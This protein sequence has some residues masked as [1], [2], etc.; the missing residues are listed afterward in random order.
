MSVERGGVILLKTGTV[1]DGKYK[2]LRQIGRGGMSVVYLAVNEKANK[3]W[4]VK[5]VY[6]ETGLGTELVRGRL[7]AETE[8]LK[9][10]HHPGL[11]AVA[12][13]IDEGES[14][15]IVMDYI[16]GRSLKEVLVREG[17][18]CREQA[19]LWGK[20]L[21]EILSYL[22]EQ[23]PPIIYRDMKPS[24]IMVQPDGN[25]KL[26]D[27]GAAREIRNTSAGEDT[28]CLGTPGYAAP[29]QWGG[30]GQ[31]DERTDI[32]CLGAVLY[33]IV[34]GKEFFF[35]SP[36]CSRT[37]VLPAGLAEI[38]E[39]CTQE[40]PK[41]RFQSCRELSY[42]LE[43]YREM[44]L[45]WRKRQKRRLM[46][47]LF[48]AFTSL[49][50]C[51][52]AFYTW[53]TEMRLAEETYRAWLEQVSS[54]VTR[55]EKE[56]ACEG[57]IRLNPGREEGYLKLLNQVFLTAEGDG[58][59]SFTR[60]EDEQLRRILNQKTADGKTYETHLKENREGYE[61]LAYE[62]GLAYYYDYEGEGNKSYGVKWLN[63]AA[64]GGT[65]P[66]ACRERALRLGTIGAYYSRIGQV[67]R[68]GDIKVSYEDYWRDLTSLAAGNLVQLDNA[69]TALRMYQ[70]LASQIHGRAPEFLQA[71]ISKEEMEEE[72]AEIRQH[73]R[74]DFE[75]ADWREPEL[76]E[77]RR[78]LMYLI[79]E[80]EKQL[81]MIYGNGRGDA[82][83][84]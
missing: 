15:L 54:S 25:L 80:A 56:A 4:A 45:P 34:T 79:E 66:E 19:L 77:M 30:C 41:K 43:H 12:D 50:C 57:A 1:I 81:D 60:E 75:S 70:E 33:E 14:L 61:R 6:S 48:T 27:F 42:A 26:I 39:K 49:L 47:F 40:D 29:E 69:V 67:S 62:L 46:S 76:K 7:M 28:V 73:L 23:K 74:E 83:N 21:C 58:T 16:E 68:A 22:H 9:R 2:I 24:N 82:E 11:P 59:V 17:A 84:E 51:I 55:E 65:L 5:E 44:E 38:L 53:H 71:G 10:L 35:R 31:T 52:G 63:I 20:Q 72:L 32:Y 13:V 37:P 3:A 8:L 36:G 78:R 64:E 18:Q